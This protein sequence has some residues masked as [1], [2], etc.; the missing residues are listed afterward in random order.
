VFLFAID[1]QLRA[2]SLQ[3]RQLSLL[4]CDDVKLRLALLHRTWKR[5]GNWREMKRNCL[6]N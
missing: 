6:S 3:R 2:V 1:T 4:F 5:S